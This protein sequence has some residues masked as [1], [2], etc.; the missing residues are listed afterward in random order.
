MKHLGRTDSEN[1]DLS[2]S[3]LILTPS[4]MA[5]DGQSRKAPG[6][7]LL[8]AAIAKTHRSQR[9]QK[10]ES[11]IRTPPDLSMTDYPGA[12]T[13]S[14]LST[15]LDKLPAPARYSP[16]SAGHRYR[17]PA[18]ANHRHG[19]ESDGPVRATEST[20]VRAA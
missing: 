19:P 12:E 2:K 11:Q 8:Y 1:P 4:S 6:L 15:V 16:C 3:R 20:R 5:G 13:T 9:L 17:R 18:G 7:R 14:N 10:E